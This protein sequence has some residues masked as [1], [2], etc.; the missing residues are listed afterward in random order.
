MLGNLGDE[1]IKEVF[2]SSYFGLDD[3]IER[4]GCYEYKACIYYESGTFDE[5]MELYID[6][7]DF[8][9][10]E[11]F[12]SRIRDQKLNLLLGKDLFDTYLF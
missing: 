1:S 3:G 8:I 4:Q 12:E 9:F 5:P 6:Y 7:I 2:E 10:L 11:S